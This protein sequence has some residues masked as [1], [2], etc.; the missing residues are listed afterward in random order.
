MKATIPLSP[1]TI[2]VLPAAAA[3][4]RARRAAWTVLAFAIAVRVAVAVLVP[5]TPDESY[6]W[7]WSRHLAAG[8]FDHPPVIALVVRFGTALLGDTALGVRLGCVLAGA[9]ASVVLVW[10]AGEMGG[11]RARP[12]AAA[13]LACMPLTQ[14]WLGI[15]TPDP[16][17]LLLWSLAL[18]ALVFALR[19]TTTARTRIIAWAFAGLALG[20]ALSTK[21]TAVLLIAGI[22]VALVAQRS[23]RYLLATPGPYIALA[24]ALVVFA[25]N[26]VW[27]ARHGWVTFDYQLAHGLAPHEGSALLREL[28]LLGGQIGLVSPLLFALLVAAVYDALRARGDALR[29]TFAIVACATWLAFAASALRTAAEPNWQAPA[30][31]SAIVL[32]ASSDCAGARARSFFRSALALGAAMTALIYL[33]TLHPFVPVNPGLD[34][35]GAGFGW[36]ALAARVATV[37]GAN[38]WIAGERYQEAS[39][40]AFHLADHPGTL[41]INVNGRPNQYDLWPSF[42]QRAHVGDRLV[43]VLKSHAGVERDPVIA[44]L[45]PHFDRI[46]LLDEVPLERGAI[47]RGTRSIWVLSGWRGSWPSTACHACAPDV[48]FR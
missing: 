30:Y 7:Q 47:V 29:T 21:Y 4:T 18:A 11:D 27:N 16:P 10:V 39:E 20:A 13:M 1:V 12:R 35:T 43:L 33:H 40:L 15:A 31:L 3:E 8:Y 19:D 28:Q 9:L 26:L 41:A 24:I 6:Y 25:P 32:A 23:L 37:R 17:L 44:A 42:A 34:A 14:I 45:S 5:L 22:G 2:I 36:D 48:N 38:S 46:T